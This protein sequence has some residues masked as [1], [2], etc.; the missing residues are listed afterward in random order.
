M[1]SAESRAFRKKFSTLISAI[2]NPLAVAVEAYSRDLVSKDVVDRML[3]QTLTTAEKAT[4]LLSCMESRISTYQESF[5]EFVR[6]LKTQTNL[7]NVAENLQMEFC[8]SIVCNTKCLLAAQN[9]S[10]V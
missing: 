2:D 9:H 7:L 10:Y 1:A 4:F 5:H 3:V 6:V 8:E